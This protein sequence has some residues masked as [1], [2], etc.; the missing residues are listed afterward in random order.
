MKD[1]QIDKKKIISLISNITFILG[2]TVAIYVIVDIYLLTSNAPAGTCPFID[3]RP[4][5]YIA[6][7]LC[8]TSLVL[9]FFGPKKKKEQTKKK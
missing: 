6:L 1:K 8:L 5:I 9:S 2:L 3:N 7:G 4:L